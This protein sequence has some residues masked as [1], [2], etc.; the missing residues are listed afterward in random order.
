MNLDQL[1]ALIEWSS[2]INFDSD[3]LEKLKKLYKDRHMRD[4]TEKALRK[5]LEGLLDFESLK[6][7]IS[8]AKELEGFDVNLLH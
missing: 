8:N 1:K 2:F 5:A 6:A 7:A 3:S 4:Q